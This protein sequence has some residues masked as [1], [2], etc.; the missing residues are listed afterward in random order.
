MLELIRDGERKF[1]D[2]LRRQSRTTE[3]AKTE[4]KRRNDAR[5]PPAGFAE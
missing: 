4:Y 2:K 1:V 5:T 3:E